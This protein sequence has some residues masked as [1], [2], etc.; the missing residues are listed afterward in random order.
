MSLADAFITPAEAARMLAWLPSI[1]D[2][3]N[4]SNLSTSA[5]HELQEFRD[6]FLRVANSRTR[7]YPSPNCK[8]PANTVSLF[9][10]KVNSISTTAHFYYTLLFLGINDCT[11]NGVTCNC[12]TGCM[13]NGRMH[14]T[15]CDGATHDSAMHTMCD[16]ALRATQDD[17]THDGAMRTT[18]DGATHD[19]TTHD[20]ATRDGTTHNGTTHN[21]T[22]HNGT[23]HNGTTQD[24]AAHD[25]T[26]H[27]MQDGACQR[28]GTK[29][30]R[31][32]TATR[33]HNKRRRI[34]KDGAMQTCFSVS[35][36]PI[37]DDTGPA[38]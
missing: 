22:T 37:C 33:Q 38:L 34:G 10:S 23:T 14:S 2:A 1:D 21:G 32:S 18:Q 15:A 3:S 8:S 19:G 6:R 27:T 16:V 30:K 4:A 36:G 12:A 9:E 35:K 5:V 11:R 26:M 29:S 31:T 24:G 25:G 20:G 17:V 13:H 28:G 7:A